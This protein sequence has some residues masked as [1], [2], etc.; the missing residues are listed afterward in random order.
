MHVELANLL[1]DQER[2]DPPSMVDVISS[3][4]VPIAIVDHDSTGHDAFSL[5]H[6]EDVTVELRTVSEFVEEELTSEQYTAQTSSAEMH[7]MDELDEDVSEVNL[8][9]SSHGLED[10][11]QMSLLQSNFV[12]IEHLG[13]CQLLESMVNVVHDPPSVHSP[14]ESINRGHTMHS[15]GVATPELVSLSTNHSHSPNASASGA[16]T[17]LSSESNSLE[18]D[19]VDF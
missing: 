19:H 2:D 3:V 6:G 14:Q 8:P 16:G 5:S 1:A 17:N 10:G 18:E 12:A 11:V 4:E 7:Y 13:D 15:A 9:N